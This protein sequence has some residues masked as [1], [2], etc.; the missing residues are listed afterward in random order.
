MAYHLL[1]DGLAQP[2]P[3]TDIPV[4]MPMEL[5][6]SIFVVNGIGEVIDVNKNNGNLKD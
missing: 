3:Y 5:H 1:V 2:A 4:A 6:Q